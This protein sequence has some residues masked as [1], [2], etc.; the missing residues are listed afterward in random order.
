VEYNVFVILRPF[1]QE[2]IEKMSELYEIA[3]FTA[4]SKEYAA[5][6]MDKIDDKKIIK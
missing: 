1:L 6:V 5:T 4:S 3:F 2:F